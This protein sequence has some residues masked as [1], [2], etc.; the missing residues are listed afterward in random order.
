VF[1]M[2]KYRILALR[3]LSCWRSRDHIVRVPKDSVTSA[4]FSRNQTCV[5]QHAGP[6][7]PAAK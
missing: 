4:D 2:K 6:T 3:T 1:L 5:S 7:S